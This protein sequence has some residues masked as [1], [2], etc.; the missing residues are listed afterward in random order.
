[1]GNYK[2]LAI[3]LD[4]WGFK[5]YYEYISRQKKPESQE[6]LFK[7][8]FCL[9]HGY[10]NRITEALNSLPQLIKEKHKG[11]ELNFIKNTQILTISDSIVITIDCTDENVGSAFIFAS[12]LLSRV[13]DESIKTETHIEEFEKF[14]YLFYLPIRGGMSCGYSITNLK[15]V[16]PFLFSCA[17]NDAVALEKRA[18][19]PRIL[20]DNRLAQTVKT[21]PIAELAISEE[22]TEKFF[23]P[24]K[25]KYQLFLNNPEMSF[26]NMEDRIGFL[27]QVA[28]PYKQHIEMCT[29]EAGN[30]YRNHI[31]THKSDEGCP[32]DPQK[33]RCWIEYYND[34]IN[35]LVNNDKDFTAREDLLIS[36]ELWPINF[37]F[38]V[39]SSQGFY[40]I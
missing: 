36:D 32:V 25:F 2:Q 21:N 40:T 30:F 23:D 12:F 27:E 13:I 7:A 31:D 9:Y 24:L 29:K 16:P 6:H 11:T 37:G 17:Y 38:P 34:R 15:S 5:K 20:I 1:M 33:Y 10:I 39:K 26:K 4:F 19:W 35:W 3:F 14:N 8:F 28:L 18:A 22:G